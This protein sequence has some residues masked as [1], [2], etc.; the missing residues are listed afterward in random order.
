M[1][2]TPPGVEA[3]DLIALLAL[4][5]SGGALVFTVYKGR[6]DQRIAIKPVLVFVYD[7]Q[8]GWFV[9][10]I[11]VGPALNVVIASH[12]ALPEGA[13]PA[14]WLEPTRIPPLKR[15]GSFVLHWVQNNVYMLGATYEDIWDRPYSTRCV[16]AL[17]TVRPGHPPGWIRNQGRMKRPGMR[18]GDSRQRTTDHSHR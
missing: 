18:P 5:V 1:Q 13:E 2:M 15:D 11:G 6:Y 16:H 17:N 14:R 8:D 10:N 4:L 9:Q 12:E 3:R 7:R